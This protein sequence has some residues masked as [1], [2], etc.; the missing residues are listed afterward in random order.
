MKTISP[1]ELFSAQKEFRIIDVRGKEEFN[2]ELGHIAGAKLVTLGP[3]LTHWLKTLPREEKLV[4][5]CRS[6]GRS[7]AATQES[8]GLGF[9]NAWNMTGGML[10]WNKSGLP[11][12][13]K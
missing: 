8:M 6:G 4:F 13:R 11:T 12:E 5:V 3:E 10:L 1:Q 7:S 9:T 2:D